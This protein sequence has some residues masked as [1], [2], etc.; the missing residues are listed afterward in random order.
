MAKSAQIRLSK[1]ATSPLT[2]WFCSSARPEVEISKPARRPSARRAIALL[3]EASS[4]AQ[5][6]AAGHRSYP[7]ACP[8]IYRQTWPAAGLFS[9]VP[10]Y[11]L[12]LAAS[13]ARP[14]FADL[15]STARPVFAGLAFDPADLFVDPAAV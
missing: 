14:P 4:D 1:A 12:P 9:P 2:A 13:F 8:L 11:L 7:R 15:S 10:F 3:P 6:L 5:R